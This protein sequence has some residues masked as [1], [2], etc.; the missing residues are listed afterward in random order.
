MEDENFQDKIGTATVVVQV[1]DV[2]DFLF[3]TKIFDVNWVMLFLVCN[4]KFTK[5]LPANIGPYFFVFVK[6]QKYSSPLTFAIIV[7]SKN[8]E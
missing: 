6:Y 8:L 4:C 5:D 7:F 1:N 3:H 2:F